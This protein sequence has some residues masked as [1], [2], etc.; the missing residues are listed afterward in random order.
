MVCDVGFLPDPATTHLYR[1]NGGEWLKVFPFLLLGLCA[2]CILSN[3]SQAHEN[4]GIDAVCT[5]LGKSWLAFILTQE[6]AQLNARQQ[7]GGDLT[8]VAAPTIEEGGTEDGSRF[9]SHYVN[10]A[11]PPLRV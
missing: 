11:R 7:K 4:T 5:Q 8:Q 3:H 10:N 1:C 2:V 9:Q 6:R